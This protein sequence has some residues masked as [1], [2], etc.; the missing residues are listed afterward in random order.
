[1]GFGEDKGDE[2][3]KRVTPSQGLAFG[4]EKIRNENTKNK[5][6]TESQSHGEKNGTTNEHE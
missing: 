5:S 1:M 4:V 3:N 2:E 6:H